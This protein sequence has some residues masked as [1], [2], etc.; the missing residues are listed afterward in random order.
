[1][2]ASYIKVALRNLSK[3]RL[4]AV[5]NVLGLAIGLTVF[6]LSVLLSNYETN[7]DYM[8]EQRD[9]IYF[10]STQFNE[11]AEIGVLE[12]DGAQ[13]A[14]GPII[15]NEVA[16]LE[17]IARIVSREYLLT[18]EGDNYFQDMKFA[19]PD[20]VKIFDLDY[21]AGDASAIQ[22]PDSLIISQST[23]EKLFGS[24][25][26]VGRT[27][28]LD[29]KHSFSIGAVYADVGADSHFNSEVVDEGKLHVIAPFAALKTIA[30]Y[31]LEGDWNN[32][33]FGDRTYI[34]LPEHLDKSWLQQ[35]IN[36]VYEKH[37]DADRKGFIKAYKARPLV[38]A[39]TMLA[40]AIGI[41]VISSIRLLGLMVLLIACVNYTNLAT[42]QSFGRVREVGL[43]KSFGANRGQLLVQFLTESLTITVLALLIAVAAI[44]LIVPFY[45]QAFGKVVQISYLEALPLLIMVAVLVGLVAGAYPAYQIA[46]VSPVDSLK[47]KNALGSGGG[48]FRSLMIGL[49][50][51]LSIFMLA[52]V[53]V[54]VFQTDKLEESSY[55][56]P[57]DQMVVLARLDAD[58]VQGRRDT[59]K[60]QLSQIKAVQT[61]SYSSQ[62]PFEQSSNSFK[63]SSSLGDSGNDI[64]ILNV[65]IDQD[66]V[67]TY[68]IKLVAGRNYDISIANDMETSEPGQVNVIINEL[69]AKRF[70]FGSAEQALGQT[71]YNVAGSDTL[72]EDHRQFE[73]TVVGVTED[74]NF[75]GLHNKLRPM[76]FFLSD[77]Y[78]KRL[79][80]RVSTHDLTN[81][82]AEIEE[83][84]GQVIPDYPIERRF[85]DD[86]F[87][88]TF[89]IMR[90]MLNILYGFSTVALTLALIGL[91]GLAAFMAER[92]TK[93]IGIRKV[94]GAKAHQVAYLLIWQFSIPVVWSLLVAIP[95]AYLASNIYLGFFA[96]RIDVLVPVLL[97]AGVIGIVTAW[98]IVSLHAFR[99]AS[100][101]PIRS[102]RYE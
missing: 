63:V 42:A 30:D 79:S 72:A 36:A 24:V 61:A 10:I 7:H 56:Y 40:D 26:V 15:R 50:F 53:L 102:L 38:E 52:T 77:R 5:I 83:I 95:A 94:L 14:L 47:S 19:D 55:I 89:V 13:S 97:L 32:L 18:I 33:S 84:W 12:T 68:D 3:H 48:L 37:L 28:E 59:L 76:M 82:L 20:F 41:P 91:F 73:Y 23:A 70:G 69:A 65:R 25:N 86:V 80:L 45:N 92:R 31:P 98:L 6:L 16:D 49:Q 1:M 93:E 96:D 81:T 35:R 100:V 66:F 51:A 22:N 101:A 39:N 21:L 78:L 87:E 99:V 74:Q 62:V 43:R 75:L 46:N 58:G 54:M 4:Y 27:L 67:Q 17:A 11:S 57:K 64:S 34:L 9:R 90:S 71:F 2:L 29:H 88:D 60:E 8:F 44:E 85:L